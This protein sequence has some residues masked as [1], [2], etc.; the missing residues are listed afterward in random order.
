MIPITEK[1]VK[2]TY[3]IGKLSVCSMTSTSSSS[4]HEVTIT[5][6]VNAYNNGIFKMESIP[7][8]FRCLNELL[9]PTQG[10]KK[11]AWV[12]YDVYTIQKT[13]Y[14]SFKVDDPNPQYAAFSDWCIPQNGGYLINK[15]T[16]RQF[17]IYSLTWEFWHMVPALQKNRYPSMRTTKDPKMDMVVHKA[18]AMLWGLKQTKA[19]Q[20]GID[21]MVVD[22]LVE[23]HQWNYALDNL[24]WSTNLDNVRKHHIEKK[25]PGFLKFP[26][27]GTWVKSCSSTEDYGEPDLSFID[28]VYDGD[29]GSRNLS[30]PYQL[31]FVR[32]EMGIKISQ[33][34]ATVEEFRKAVRETNMSVWK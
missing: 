6:C 3:T 17:P 20:I 12:D 8:L 24:D 31:R 18:V 15:R 9:Y 28:P 14:R 26:M 19:T 1:H 22:H 27:T 11:D 5:D 7:R 23:G 16:W 4:S 13:E 32:T 30:K 34:F 33:N 10:I 25:K 21:S 29:M 2:E